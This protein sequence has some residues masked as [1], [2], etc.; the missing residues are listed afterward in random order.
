[1]FGSRYLSAKLAG[2]PATPSDVASAVRKQSNAY[3]ELP[4]GYLDGLHYG[5]QDVQPAA[6]ASAEAT[7]TIQ[8]VCK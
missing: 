4:I 1:D 3:Q 5:D 2:E 6:N 8:R 7:A